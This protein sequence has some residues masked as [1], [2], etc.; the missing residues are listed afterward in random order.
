M[1]RELSHR[2]S[3]GIEVSLRWNSETNQVLV[4][5]TEDQL[6]ASFMFE[7]A[8]EDALDAFH[9]PYAYAAHRR[10]DGAVAA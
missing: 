2:M 7:V 9:H 3:D 4:T 6:G 1:I 8:A 10:Y 5:V